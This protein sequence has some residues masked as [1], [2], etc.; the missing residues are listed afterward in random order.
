MNAIQEAAREGLIKRFFRNWGLG[1]TTGLSVLENPTEELDHEIARGRRPKLFRLFGAGPAPTA[2][3][4][5][6][7][8]NYLYSTRR[9][10]SNTA[11]N[12]IGAGAVAAGD[13]DFFGNGQGDSGNSMGYFSIGNLTYLQTNMEKGGKIPRGKGYKLYELGVSFNSQALGADISQLLD[14]C[15][16]KF[17]MGGGNFTIQHGP[18]L[19][20]PGGVGVA[21]YAGA[22]TT[23]AATTINVERASNGS[24]FLG[25]AR[26]LKDPRI[27]AAN[28]TFKYTVTAAANTPR[29]NVAVALSDFVEMRIWLFGY[30]YDAIKQ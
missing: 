26:R 9:F 24:P 25:A 20:W 15:N 30:H 27:L 22:A 28:D 17:D 2:R 1:P 7:E 10:P 6:R 3:E 8:E 13:Y 14:T 19:L 29:T 4:I 5:R 12:T 21:G 16:L 11:N 18:I 23:V